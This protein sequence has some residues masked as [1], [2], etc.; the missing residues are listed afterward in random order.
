MSRQKV[1][2]T[3]ETSITH[4]GTV[5]VSGP[6]APSAKNEDG[7]RRY[8]TEAIYSRQMTDKERKWTPSYP[9]LFSAIV[10]CIKNSDRTRA[11]AP[12]RNSQGAANPIS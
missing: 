6:R 4:N 2:D 1:S 3:K 11:E 8:E 10:A 9:N 5:C 7:S 12:R